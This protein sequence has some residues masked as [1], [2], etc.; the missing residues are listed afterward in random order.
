MLLCLFIKVLLSCMMM[1]L[2]M[3]CTLC[4]DVVFIVIKLLSVLFFGLLVVE[5]CFGLY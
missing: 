5:G 3:G 4:V 1:G 2:D